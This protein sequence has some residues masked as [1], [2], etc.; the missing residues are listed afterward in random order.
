MPASTNMQRCHAQSRP[1]SKYWSRRPAA[2]VLGGL[3]LVMN[4]ARCQEQHIC[5]MLCWSHRPQPGRQ[6]PGAG[7]HTLCPVPPQVYLEY[8]S[9]PAMQK[10]R[11]RLLALGV[12]GVLEGRERAV[13]FVLVKCKDS[14]RCHPDTQVSSCSTRS[15]LEMKRHCSVG[16]GV[17]VEFL[18]HSHPM[19]FDH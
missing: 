5:S 3:L 18:G 8:A 1:R 10:E 17:A 11:C 4:A 6:R 14:V 9:I 2:R 16:L 7:K 12:L 19:P 13:P 15:A